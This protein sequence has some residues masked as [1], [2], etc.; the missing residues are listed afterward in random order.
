MASFIGIK[1][2]DGNFYP[3]LS[4]KTAQRKRLVL[5]TVTD[6]QSGVQIDLYRSPAKTMTNARYIGSLVLENLPPKKKGE[7]SIE[8]VIDYSA[9]G[10]ISAYAIDLDKNNVGDRQMLTVSL[11]SLDE[12]D[13]K[14][15]DLVEG[16]L[17][18][19]G[20]RA[21]V[22]HYDYSERKK[23][24]FIIVLITVFALAVAGFAVWF[25]LLN[26]KAA[27]GF[28]KPEKQAVQAAP[29]KQTPAKTPRQPEPE[30][31]V[32]AI[33]EEPETEPVAAIE[34]AEAEQRAAP[35]APP[36]P[37]PPPSPSPQTASGTGG[38]SRSR[39]AVPATRADRNRP[40]PPVSSY[41]VPYPIPKDG[42]W[43]TIR[44]G[45]TLWAISEAF[46]RNPWDY[47]FLARYNGIKNPALIISGNRL[48]IPP[49]R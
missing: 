39:P 34:T 2:A 29:V 19:D 16:I 45:D 4:E 6:N 30:P 33:V 13:G 1:L 36:P 37:P 18:S 35:P 27:F 9:D 14:E 5:T 40:V 31:E 11:T 38:E 24:V 10:E 44:W 47:R 41:N 23:P 48:K 22:S 15:F 32:P 43:Y 7:P 3:I 8:M 17:E 46:Y 42:V 25:F 20:E 12:A 21:A 26:G 28:S 49:R